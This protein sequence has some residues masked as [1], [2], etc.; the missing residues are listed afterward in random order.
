VAEVELQ[1]LQVAMLEGV[2]DPERRPQ[3]HL[4]HPAREGQRG[5]VGLGRWRRRGEGRTT[6]RRSVS[7]C[8]RRGRGFGDS[9]DDTGIRRH[10]VGPRG[11]HRDSDDGSAGPQSRSWWAG[12]PGNLW[13]KKPLI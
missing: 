6:A 8:D 4:L 9:M 1:L 7:S 11:R 12:P 10:G 5:L 2:P 3:V 13:N